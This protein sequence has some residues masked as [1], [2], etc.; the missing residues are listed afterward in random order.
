MATAI[1]EAE[2]R[3]WSQ[4]V[5]TDPATVAA[6]TEVVAATNSLVSRRCLPFASDWPNEVHTAALIQAS[7]LY[8]RRGSPEG[9]SSFGDFGVVSITRFD[10]DIEAE[11]SP[12]LKVTFA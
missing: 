4:I 10:A 1:T 2:V 7:R 12:Y 8:K 3:D 6:L 9:V 5:A 11:L